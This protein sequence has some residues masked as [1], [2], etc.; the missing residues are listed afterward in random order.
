MANTVQPLGVSCGIVCLIPQYGLGEDIDSLKT[1]SISIS[2]CQESSGSSPL[3]LCLFRNTLSRGVVGKD[4]CGCFS[5]FVYLISAPCS[6]E[7]NGA[8]SIRIPE[9]NWPYIYL[10]LDNNFSSRMSGFD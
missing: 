8:G 3:F 9:I 6:I 1:Q 2:S 10:V 4:L 7:W 5:P